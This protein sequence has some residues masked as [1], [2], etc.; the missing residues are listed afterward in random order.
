MALLDAPMRDMAVAL[1]DAFGVSSTLR[2]TATSYAPK[3][4]ADIASTTDYTVNASP[5]EDYDVS[6]IDGTVIKTND[7]K[8]A[9]AAKGL[10]VEP[11]PGKDVFLFGGVTYKIISVKKVYS[12]AQIAAFVLQCRK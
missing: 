1:I 2:R 4:G 8:T 12:G 7:F 11:D 10:A 9:V 6:E 3:D 5:P